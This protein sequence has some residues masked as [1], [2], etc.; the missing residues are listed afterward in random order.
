[1][2]REFNLIS[3]ALNLTRSV[4][5]FMYVFY[6][7][8]FGIY[9]IRFKRVICSSVFFC[10]GFLFMKLIDR[11]RWVLVSEFLLYVCVDEQFLIEI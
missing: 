9:L 1:M 5:I 6:F 3:L 8:E 4:K 7:W 11:S 10:Y 2:K